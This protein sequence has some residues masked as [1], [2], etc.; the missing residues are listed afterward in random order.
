MKSLFT[1]LPALFLFSCLLSTD[2]KVDL[3][4]FDFS[5]TDDSEIFFK[6]VRQ[7]EYE[8]IEM[9][10]ARMNI[11]QMTGLSQ[12]SSLWPKII[13]NWSLD[14]ASIWLETDTALQKPISI[15][16]T[17]PTS[18][19]TILFSGETR[20]EHLET[21]NAIF[22]AILDSSKV[23]VNDQEIFAMGSSQRKDFRVVMND[24]FRLVGLK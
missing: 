7:S 13:H 17:T 1:I 10:E 22:E 9:K 18:S 24:Y 16:I 15:L 4:D 19:N 20:M 14:Q 8:I 6:N 23:F 3:N 11:F 12:T 21:S 5:T 2:Q